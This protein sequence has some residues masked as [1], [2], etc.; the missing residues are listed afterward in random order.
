MFIAGW[1]ATIEPH[2]MYTIWAEDSIPQL[3]SVAYINKDVEELFQQG[4]ATYDTEVRRQK[5]QEA[6]MIITDEAPYIF[7]FYNKAWSGQNNRIQGIEPKPL[8]IGWNSEDWYIEEDP[9]Q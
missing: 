9:G 3:N 7:L 5:Y 1:R 2:I 8:G 6:Q 4:G